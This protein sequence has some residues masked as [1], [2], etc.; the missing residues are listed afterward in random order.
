MI[1]AFMHN[2]ASLTF[3]HDHSLLIDVMLL[4]SLSEARQ[5]ALF[6]AT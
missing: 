5:N 2:Y 3:M 4:S 6:H 1:V